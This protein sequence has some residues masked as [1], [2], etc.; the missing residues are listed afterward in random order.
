MKTLD[1]KPIKINIAKKPD[2][3]IAKASEIVGDMWTLLIIREL[4]R[5]TKRFNEIQQA[6]VSVDSN[7]CINS[8]TLTERLKV[9]EKEKILLRSAVPHEMP[10]RVEYE[11]TKKGEALSKIVADLKSFGRKYL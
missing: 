4:L 6:L 5:G 3:P 8:R 10:P 2:C 9:L 7:H 11:L 1:K